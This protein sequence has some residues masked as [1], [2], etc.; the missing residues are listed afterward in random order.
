MKKLSSIIKK[1]NIELNN[2][3]SNS[4]LLKKSIRRKPVRKKE[5]SKRLLQIIDLAAEL[6]ERPFDE[7]QPLGFMSRLLVM[8]NLPYRD[9]GKEAR[10]WW[11]TNGA[12]SINVTPGY[13]GKKSI[14]I[15]YG[16]YPRLILAYL[17]TQAVRT[18]SPEIFLGK[19]FREFLDLVC[20]NDG[21]KQYKQ[22]LKQI[23]R[24]TS[25]NFSWTYENEKVWSRTN[26][27]VSHQSQLWWNPKS[28]DQQSLWESKVTLNTDF[29]NE[30]IRNAVPLD[31]RVLKIFKNSPLGLD[32]YMFLSWRTFNFKGPAFISWEGLHTQLGG[33]YR[34]LKEF[35]RDC[36]KHIKRIQSVWPELNVKTVR[37]RLCIAPMS[38][39]LISVD[40]SPP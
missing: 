7:T 35:G 23:K 14:G 34:N 29:F 21:S 9:P 32:L 38:K 1:E 40:K 20:I 37:G 13:D 12:V 11:K 6:A 3:S 15:P 25:A 27:Q 8:V 18:K 36:R 28:P 2:N 19:T 31:F 10:N 22:L 17:I 4:D 39:N 33:Q 16:V 26:I 24:T 30:I 5:V